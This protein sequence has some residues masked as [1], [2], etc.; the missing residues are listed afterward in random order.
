MAVCAADFAPG[1]LFPEL[2]KRSSIPGK[3]VHMISLLIE[4]IEVEDRWIALPAI[5]A[6]V[7]G[8]VFSDVGASRLSAAR[9][10]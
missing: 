2:R 8:E 1:E 6:W 5:H 4:V 10:C 9:S 3:P 7:S